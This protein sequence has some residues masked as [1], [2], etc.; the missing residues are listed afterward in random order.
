M[1]GSVL[2]IGGGFSGLT[3]AVEAAEMGHDV[4]IVE[5]QSYLGGRVAQL[6][7]YFPK[8][9]PPTCGLEIN[10]KRVKTSPRITFYTLAEVESVSGG[11]GNY[12]VRVRVNP[13]YTTPQCTSCEAGAAAATTEVPNEFNFGMD[14]R[15]PIYM[16]H[17]MAFPA[18]CVVDPAVAGTEEGEAIKAAMPAG[19]VDLGQQ[20][21][22]VTLNVGAIVVATG[23]APYDAGKIDNLGFG[24]CTNVVTNMMVERMA[25]PAGPTGGKILRPS[26]QAE[27]KSVAFVQCAGS[28]DEN[29]L[30]Y[31]SYICCMATLKQA[32]YLREQSPDTEIY[33]FYIDIRAPGRKYENFY[34]RVKEDEKIHFV[35]GKVAEVSEDPATK[36]VKVVAEDAV[37]G[38]KI[39]QEVD[40]AVLATGMQPTGALKAIPGIEYDQDGFVVPKEGII[41]CGCALRPIDVVSSAQ[42]ATAAALKAVQTLRRAG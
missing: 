24:R 22:T 40:L 29:H 15:K 20:P 6:N 16:P 38:G 39:E 35:K 30:P 3:A 1:S 4:Y 10:F 27:P 31:C 18:Q 37:G 19:H 17:P 13:R 8:L 7:K 32:L 11:P 33:V 21:E 26:D 36:A 12:E 2:V 9:C 25:S 5:G 42:S 23:W 34:K 14:T 41:P 28:R